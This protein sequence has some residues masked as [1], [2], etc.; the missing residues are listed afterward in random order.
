MATISRPD[1]SVARSVPPR[2]LAARIRSR[3]WAWLL[4]L[5]EATLVAIV[6]HLVTDIQQLGE[7]LL[8]GVLFL[9]IAP[10]QILFGATLR[11]EVVPVVALAAAVL[12]L[13]VLGWYVYSRVGTPHPFATGQG[14][15]VA[16]T[17]VLA[18]ELIA[19]GGVGLAMPGQLRRWVVRSLL[20][21]GIAFWLVW[22]FALAL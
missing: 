14:A 11:R 18:V 2:S 4:L 7:P 5:A 1:G 13:L 6:L 21:L 20:G 15:N 16:G 17:V 10:L 22:F 19:V 12:A 9:G 8:F 3:R